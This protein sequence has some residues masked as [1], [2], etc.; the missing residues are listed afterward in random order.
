MAVYLLDLRGPDDSVLPE[1]KGTP[2]PP[3]S[4]YV[5]LVHGYNNDRP[6]A[7]ASYREF[8]KNTRL[9]DG[10]RVVARVFWPGDKRWGDVSFASYPL[11]ITPAIETAAVLDDYIALLPAPGPWPPEVTLVCHSLGNRVGFE[12]VNR[13]T[14]NLARPRIDYRLCSMA[15]ATPVSFVEP[16]GRL[17][18]GAIGLTGHFI[19]YSG[20]DWVLRG[21][22]PIGE[23]LAGEGFFPSAIGRQGKPTELWG[24]SFSREMR[25]G[26]TGPKY[27][28]GD[29]WPGVE[30]AALARRFVAGL[31]TAGV[32]ARLTDDN[33]IPDR[34]T[35][36][37]T[38]SGR[39]LP[40]R[41][42]F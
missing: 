7:E 32:T 38:I 41:P 40:E 15:A 23:T 14:L 18:A 33:T 28:H 1:V 42:A 17:M 12:I 5:L 25:K 27:G 31:P 6:H 26:E 2:L 35:P 11:E 13:A 39:S 30:S 20:G 24:T 16:G 4:R 29:Y 9:D 37:A 22:F 8:L 19:M 36:T 21:G 3:S 34:D 10:A